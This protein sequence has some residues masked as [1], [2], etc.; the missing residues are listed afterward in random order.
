MSDS[1][2]LKQFKHR[3]DFVVHSIFR[4][5]NFPFFSVGFRLFFFVIPSWKWRGLIAQAHTIWIYMKEKRLRMY[6]VV[7]KHVERLTE[8]M[9]NSLNQ[10]LWLI[11]W[12]SSEATAFWRWLL[13]LFQHAFRFCYSHI[14]FSL[15]IFFSL[16]HILFAS[17]LWML[18]FVF[19][20]CCFIVFHAND[21]NAQYSFSLLFSYGEEHFKMADFHV[22]L[23]HIAF[24]EFIAFHFLII[25][26][27]INKACSMW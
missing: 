13:M 18:L 5:F 11:K 10:R 14:F 24:I 2:K 23:Q 7:E 4:L 20:Y 21:E 3:S 26:I 1:W 17:T 19:C 25:L 27:E 15:P 6:F 22:L 16:F 9:N 8:F 12:I